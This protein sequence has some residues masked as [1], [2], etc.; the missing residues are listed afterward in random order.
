MYPR[1]SLRAP[2][3]GL[4]RLRTLPVLA[5]GQGTWDGDLRLQVVGKYMQIPFRK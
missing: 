2:E 3:D 1:A 5:W 4:S